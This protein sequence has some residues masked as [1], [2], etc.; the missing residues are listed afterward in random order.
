MCLP[1]AA[2]RGRSPR[3][4]GAGEK[5]PAP[6]PGAYLLAG[7]SRP[8]S[9]PAKERTKAN[10]RA[11]GPRDLSLDGLAIER[12]DRS[13]FL[14]FSDLNFWRYRIWIYDGSHHGRGTGKIAGSG[15]WFA[16]RYAHCKQFAGAGQAY[17]A[18]AFCFSCNVLF[19]GDGDRASFFS[20][21]FSS[22]IWPSNSPNWD[23]DP[24]HWSTIE[25]R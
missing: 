2:L 5:T 24:P 4:R 21:S 20:A 15:Q 22:S 1:P 9:E 10:H 18:E 7:R 12:A 8:K 25:R 14:R 23:H 11:A 16:V 13:Q 19:I 17:Y 6:Q 3:G